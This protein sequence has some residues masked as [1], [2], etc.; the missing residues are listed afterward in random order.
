MNDPHQPR[1]LER[2]RSTLRLNLPL[3]PLIALSLLPKTAIALSSPYHKQRSRF[4]PFPQTAIALPSPF[5]KQRS[6][7]FLLLQNLALLTN[8]FCIDFQ[9]NLG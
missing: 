7:S 3:V 8:Q 4:L 6:C 2:V 9:V 1:L 5:Q